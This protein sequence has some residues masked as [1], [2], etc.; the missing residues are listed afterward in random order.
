MATC[1]KDTYQIQQ[2]TYVLFRLC[3]NWT[4][5]LAATL[6]KRTERFQPEHFFNH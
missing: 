5:F 4:M 3:L 2:R 6:V 1:K